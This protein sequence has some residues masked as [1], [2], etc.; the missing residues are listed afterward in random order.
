MDPSSSSSSEPPVVGAVC[1]SIR[2]RTMAEN[3]LVVLLQGVQGRR[4]TVELRDESSAR[5]TVLSVDA[6]MNVRLSDV[7]F[8][9][10]AGRESRLQ[11]MF[12]TA[13]NVR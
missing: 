12:V 2:E 9:D 11:D 8:R 13:R 6:F 5:G 4:T 10:R 1:H 3:S 7:L